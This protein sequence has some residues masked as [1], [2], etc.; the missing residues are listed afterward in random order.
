MTVAK[1]L[2]EAYLVQTRNEFG[3][4]Q[5]KITLDE[6][7]TT[8]ISGWDSTAKVADN[9]VTSNK[10]PIFKIDILSH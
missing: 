1:F 5:R 7:K 3:D 6:G 8:R 9:L 4:E 2:P 10:I